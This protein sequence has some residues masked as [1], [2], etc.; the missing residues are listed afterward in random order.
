[1]S[2]WKIFSIFNF[3]PKGGGERKIGHDV[4]RDKENAERI[5]RDKT[6]K[7]GREHYVEPVT[8]E[9]AW[10]SASAKENEKPDGRPGGF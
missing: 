8:R 2:F 10:E 5:A 7:S 1:M 9:Q 3:G 6:R 4:V